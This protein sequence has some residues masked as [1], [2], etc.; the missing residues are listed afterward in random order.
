VRLDPRPRSYFTISIIVAAP[1]SS[2]PS[3]TAQC[4]SR[5]TAS[6]IH[7]PGS[8]QVSIRWPLGLDGPAGF[9][10]ASESTATSVSV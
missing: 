4:L 1:R 2:T 7:S 9:A 6:T 10:L 5:F 3:R 8:S